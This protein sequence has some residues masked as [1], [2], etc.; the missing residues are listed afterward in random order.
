[1]AEEGVFFKR[2]LPSL[3]T[4]DV[5]VREQLEVREKLYAKDSTYAGDPNFL[6]QYLNANNSFVKLTSGIDIVGTKKIRM[7]NL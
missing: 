5:T 4:I 7:L 3:S 6:A 2:P 1:M